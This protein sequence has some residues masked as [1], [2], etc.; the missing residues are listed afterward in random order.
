MILQL[1]LKQALVNWEN[2]TTLSDR[3]T[4]VLYCAGWVRRQGRL[5]PTEVLVK[6][7][8]FRRRMYRNFLKSRHFLEMGISPEKVFAFTWGPWCRAYLRLGPEQFPSVLPNPP[9]LIWEGYLSVLLLVLGFLL[10]SLEIFLPTP[11]IITRLKLK[12]F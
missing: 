9:L 12:S 8:L 1:L 6:K 3:S 5:R 4:V 7:H 11:L 10:P 2:V